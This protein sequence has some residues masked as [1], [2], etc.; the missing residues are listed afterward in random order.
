MLPVRSAQVGGAGEGHLVC[1]H[2]WN[3]ALLKRY[4]SPVSEPSTSADWAFVISILV[5]TLEVMAAGILAILWLIAR[6]WQLVR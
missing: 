6:L 4:R 1:T 3:A 2:V 5:I